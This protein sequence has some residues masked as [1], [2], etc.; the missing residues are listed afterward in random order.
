MK[1]RIN[2]RRSIKGKAIAIGA[3]VAVVSLVAFFGYR[4]LVPVNASVPVLSFPQNEFVKAVHSQ[5]GYHYISQAPGSVKG[6]RSA[7]PHVNPSYTYPRGELVTF[8]VINEDD[9]THEKHNLNI[10][11]F[12]VHTKDLG[13]FTSETVTFV[14]DKAGTF[15]YYCSI[16]PEMNGTITVER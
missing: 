4:A 8:H 6:V 3:A 1:K 14:A 5:S 10:D 12:G 13:Y 7:A 11:E 16:H 15:K 2:A 9:Q